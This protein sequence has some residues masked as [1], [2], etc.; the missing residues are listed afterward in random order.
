MQAPETK[1]G[2][3]KAVILVIMNLSTCSSSTTCPSHHVSIPLE[4]MPAVG[5]LGQGQGA[6][7]EPVLL[8]R[9]HAQL[10]DTQPLP[11]RIASSCP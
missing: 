8:Y 10:E 2:A 1:D 4:A 11:P 9:G 5:Y 3:K 6:A 7:T